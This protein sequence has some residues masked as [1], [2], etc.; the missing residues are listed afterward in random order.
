[1]D[2]F[3][4]QFWQGLKQGP[5]SIQKCNRC[6]KNQWYPRS[7]C[8][9][10]GSR[11]LEWIRSTGKGTLYS[12]TIIRRTSTERTLL[13]APYV[14]GLV[15]LDEGVRLF[16]IIDVIVE[17]DLKIGMRL[18]FKERSLNYYEFP[19]VFET[20]SSGEVLP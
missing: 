19:L 20:G 3:G 2:K 10:C 16:A 13:H 18:K 6:G 5:P 1:M 9:N 15:Q 4:D 12:Y 17:A 7:L 8:V 14:I 11:E